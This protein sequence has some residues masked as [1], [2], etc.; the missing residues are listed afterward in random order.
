MAGIVEQVRDGVVVDFN[1][2]GV[3]H[4]GAAL[5]TSFSAKWFDA[6]DHTTAGLVAHVIG[7]EMRS[8]RLTRNSEGIEVD[9]IVHLNKKLD[10]DTIAEVDS[11]AEL[12]EKCE[13]FY[14]STASVSTVKATL[15]SSALQLPTRKMLNKSRRFYGWARLTF[16]LIRNH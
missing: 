8:Q 11:L 14:Y 10:G 3:A 4:F 13:A 5:T 12:L 2:A 7:D 15:R 6:T 16:Y 9:V 1:A